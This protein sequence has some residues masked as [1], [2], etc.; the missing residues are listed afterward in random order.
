MNDDKL[1]RVYK[2]GL[3]KLYPRMQ[4]LQGQLKKVQLGYVRLSNAK[5]EIELRNATVK[6]IPTVRPGAKGGSKPID[7]MKAIDN[8]NE[9]QMLEM[10]KK[11][12]KKL[13]K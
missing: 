7:P 4:K 9:E 13:G 10:I 11:L 8:L 1:I 5:Y 2:R 3:E 12:E 6:V